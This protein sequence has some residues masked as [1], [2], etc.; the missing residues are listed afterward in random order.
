MADFTH[1]FPTLL[2]HEGGYCHDLQDPGGETYKGIARV[3]NPKWSGWPTVDAV[4]ARAALP[5]P[6][7][8]AG[9]RAL[10]K[11]LEAE[12]TLNALIMSFYKASYWNPLSLDAV[13]SQCVAEQLA[14]HGVNAG[15]ARPAKM[16]Q[17]LLATEFGVKLVVDG[18]VGSVPR[19]DTGIDVVGQPACVVVLAAVPR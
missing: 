10:S 3:S 9:W 8:R 17:Y 18:Q 12:A 5:T 2:A 13:L 1:Y 14:D 16:L 4:K 15:T 6:V 11:A 19:I 7:P